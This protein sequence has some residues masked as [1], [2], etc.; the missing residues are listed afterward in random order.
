[1]SDESV[2][3]NLEVETNVPPAP[4]VTPAVETPSKRQMSFTLGE[5]GVIRAEFGEG[6]EPL[7]LNVAEVPEAI[8]ALAVGE[9]IISRLRGY[10]SKLTEQTRT[11][12]NLRTAI[13]K[14][15]ENI[16]AGTWKVERVSAT[17]ET[18]Y[19]I[20]VEA[21]YLF[22]V[23]RYEKALAKAKADGI[24]YTGA[25]PG[26]IEE[27]AA[28][29]KT[30]TEDTETVSVDGKKVKTLGQKSQLKALPLY[31]LAYA[32]VKQRRN[33][34]KLAKL[35]AAVEKDEDNAPM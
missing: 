18:E 26:T 6:I 19:P 12:E 7:S 33:A 31:Q 35:A 11:P 8:Y 32:E 1:M 24:D 5:D 2:Q 9:G 4:A 29:Y 22:K 17:G 34:E 30:L 23:K 21:A 13:S 16:L 27:A 15:M 25:M 3:T 10:T 20:E 28:A 14:G